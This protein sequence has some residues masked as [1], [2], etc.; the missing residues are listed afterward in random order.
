MNI[1]NL[2]KW[3]D[4][5]IEIDDICSK[6]KEFYLL[7]ESSLF[8]LLWFIDKDVTG[9]RIYWLI[10]KICIHCLLLKNSIKI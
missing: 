7:S 5:F 8:K 4:W 9:K 6:A 3:K 1:T 10:L 2:Q